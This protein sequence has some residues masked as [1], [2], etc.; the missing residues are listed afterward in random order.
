MPDPVSPAS[1][2]TPE[3]IAR[4]EDYAN[5]ARW[6]GQSSYVVSIAV[7]CVIGLSSLGQRFTRRLPGPWLVRL[8]LTVV[9]VLLLQRAILLPWTLLA[10]RN[11]LEFGLTTQS[12]SG[13][14]R[15][16]ATNFAVTAGVTFL[17][18][19]ILVGCARRW[20]R[21]WPAIAGL[22]LMA[23]TLAGSFVYPVLIEPLFNNF[24]SLPSGPLRQ[25]VIALA[26]VEN[27]PLKTSSWRMPLVVRRV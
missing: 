2:F 12:L 8:L 10:R 7:L 18:L 27:V 25:Q 6:I 11:R 22:V 19:A 1:V 20:R 23:L 26:D 13:F 21:T 9:G 5:T 17:A 14:V 3:Q 4:S 16:L 24:T 15:D